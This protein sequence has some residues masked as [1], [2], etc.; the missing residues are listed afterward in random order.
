M[1]NNI[2]KAHRLMC[3]FV[4]I[5]G[6]MGKFRLDWFCFR[7]LHSTLHIVLLVVVQLVVVLVIVLVV[8]L[9]ELCIVE[10]LVAVLLPLAL[11]LAHFVTLAFS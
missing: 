2:K 7:I 6:N 11:A 10:L 1:K 9:V 8:L 3:F 5:N 4:F